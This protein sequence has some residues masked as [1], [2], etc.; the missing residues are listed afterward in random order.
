MTRVDP[1]YE[2]VKKEELAKLSRFMFQPR[3]VEDETST[4]CD[5]EGIALLDEYRKYMYEPSPAAHQ[6]INS[7]SSLPDASCSSKKSK[8]K[9]KKQKNSKDCNNNFKGSPKTEEQARPSFKDLNLPQLY[10][11]EVAGRPIPKALPTTIIGEPMLLTVKL[12]GLTRLDSMEK[13]TKNGPLKLE[14]DFT[15]QFLITW[16]LQMV[17]K[18]QDYPQSDCEQEEVP[19]NIVGFD[20]SSRNGELYLNA[21]ALLK[22]EHEPD[23]IRSSKKGKKKI[24]HF[25]ECVNKVKKFMNNNTVMD[26]I[27]TVWKA[28]PGSAL[29]DII[30]V[31]DI[32][33]SDRKMST[34]VQVSNDSDAIERVFGNALHDFEFGL[35]REPPLDI[36]NNSASVNMDNAFGLIHGGAFNNGSTIMEMFLR[37]QA[38]CMDI[39]AMRLVWISKSEYNNVTLSQTYSEEH[40]E[41]MD[42]Y[43]PVLALGI[44]GFNGV[45]SW[46]D[47]CG[48][49]NVRV[50]QFTDNNSL[51]ANHGDYLFQRLMI[52]Q[53][54]LRKL[55]MVKDVSTMMSEVSDTCLF[56]APRSQDRCHELYRLF[57]GGELDLT[58]LAQKK[59]SVAKIRSECRYHYCSYH[60]PSTIVFLISHRLPLRY[61]SDFTRNLQNYG[62]SIQAIRRI[63][64]LPTNITS[65][66]SEGYDKVIGQ[67]ETG[68]CVLAKREN[69]S[70]HWVGIMNRIKEELLGTLLRD[71]P[72][73]LNAVLRHT[74]F[75]QPL[76][77][78]LTRPLSSLM[79]STPKSLQFSW[80]PEGW[81][82]S[83]SESCEQTTCLILSG[84]HTISCVAITLHEILNG[85]ETMPMYKL[86]DDGY[87]SGGFELVA[88]RQI[89]AV[90]EFQARE[91]VNLDPT[92]K[93]YDQRVNDLY[94]NPIM[95]LVLRRIQAI[96]FVEE[97]VNFVFAKRKIE[98]TYTDSASWTNRVINCVFFPYELQEDNSTRAHLR[99]WPTPTETI[100]DSLFSQTVPTQIVPFLLTPSAFNVFSNV[101]LSL[102]E[103]RN[104]ELVSLRLFPQMDEEQGELLA[105]QADIIEHGCRTV[106]TYQP[107]RALSEFHWKKSSQL[108]QNGTSVLFVVRGPDIFRRITIW[109]GLPDPE[110]ARDFC[111]GSIRAKYGVDRRNSGVHLP[112]DMDECEE[113]IVGLCSAGAQEDTPDFDISIDCGS[114]ADLEDTL[115]QNVMLVFELCRAG[116]LIDQFN[117]SNFRIIGLRTVRFT[118]NTA[119]KI[120]KSNHVS[121]MVANRPV[122]C[123]VVWRSSNCLQTLKA[124]N[125]DFIYQSA[126]YEDAAD[127]IPK[128]FAELLVS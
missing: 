120:F 80:Q 71:K 122:L 3:K 90:N 37:I 20:I 93:N 79:C 17:P 43:I 49:R 81:N 36:S 123:A 60:D 7:W 94:D 83:L 4:A 106:E 95:V 104:C 42:C 32:S 9:A 47:I 44:R 45:T 119:K 52:S 13:N 31:T 117:R 103:L 46:Q 61:L 40:L 114:L 25:D 125:K 75:C 55:Q 54:N 48:P 96:K 91:I 109:A 26:V 19:F 102:L 107:G 115:Q 69:A 5:I 99:F 22:K 101:L 6:H 86:A 67:D 56:Y 116:E 64:T 14:F 11:P 38:E 18:Y 98:M 63:A 88:V 50:A 121:K 29:H 30:R 84:Q 51:S 33:W 111:P 57:F 118:R 62:C 112:K 128:V 108:W 73:Q 35:I 89:Y 23:Q 8:S 124:L 66:L 110:E 53:S 34:Y 28:E 21:C 126:S 68:F 82:E 12:A 59:L 127:Q 1:L 10:D 41:H 85:Q 87:Q 78:E 72:H 97:Y 105:K 27:S 76:T 70:L 92:D 2:G 24:S 39:T 100:P 16:F 77:A 74:I 113:L 65:L 58:S 15:Y